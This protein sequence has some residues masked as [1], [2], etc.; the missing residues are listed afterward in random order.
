MTLERIALSADV[1]SRRTLRGLSFL[2]KRGP[3]LQFIRRVASLL[4]GTCVRTAGPVTP[5]L[6]R[7]RTGR[8]VLLAV[9][10]RNPPSR[11]EAVSVLALVLLLLIIVVII[12]LGPL[13]VVLNVRDS[14]QL[15]LLFLRTDLGAL[16]VIREGTLLGNENRPNSVRTLTLDRGI[17]GQHREQAFLSYVPVI[18]VGFLRLGFVTQ[19][20]L[21][22]LCPTIWPRRVQTKP[23]FGAAF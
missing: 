10:L 17:L 3:Y 21:T 14:V 2:M 13:N 20:T 15:S 7:R 22:L 4:R 18:T 12:R 5:H 11:Y 6:P 8:I 1:T 9:G 19:T 23:R 16:G